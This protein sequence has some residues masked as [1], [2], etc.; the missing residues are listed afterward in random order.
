[1]RNIFFLFLL[2]NLCFKSAFCQK[3]QDLNQLDNIALD[4]KN[5]PS[6]GFELKTNYSHIR[7]VD[8]RYDGSKLGFA[9]YYGHYRKVNLEKGI[10][11]LESYLNQCY[12]NQPQSNRP[13]LVLF[14]KTLWLQ[15]LKAGEKLRNTYNDDQQLI[16]TCQLQVDAFALFENTYRA[17]VR[18]DTSFELPNGVRYTYPDLLKNSFHTVIRK[19]K[20]FDDI[21][22]ISDRKVLKPEEV[23]TFYNTRI[24]KLKNVNDR[25]TEKGIYLTYND[26]LN[27][28]LTKYNF[29][30]E[31]E[32]NADYL[33]IEEN[34][35]KKL[36][37][38]FWGFDNGVSHYI[39]VGR[40]FF[41]LKKDYNTYSFWGCFQA[42]HTSKPRSENRIA[43]YA[44]FGVF[45]ELHHN[46]LAN[47]LR[48]M[49]LNADTGLPY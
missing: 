9:Y 12:S 45:S 21:K 33:Y 48:P 30:I 15:D 34:G 32:E 2:I 22:L 3:L 49:Q 46:A 19:L 5:D 13:E 44:L 20:P 16:S 31:Q 27:N 26:F 29:T 10:S 14:V 36:F 38:D 11:T 18:V 47:Y 7:I 39:K 1:M 4:L 24:Q 40:N 6:S 17:L 35:E 43:R 25:V 23:I 42:L 8:V 28:H 41:E 37:T